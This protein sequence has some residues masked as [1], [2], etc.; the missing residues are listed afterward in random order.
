MMF[1]AVQKL[2]P[3][4]IPDGTNWSKIFESYKVADKR[5]ATPYK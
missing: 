1:V 4:N 2:G 5:S 3:I